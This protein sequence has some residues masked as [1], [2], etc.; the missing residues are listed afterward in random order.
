MALPDPECWNLSAETRHRRASGRIWTSGRRWLRYP[1]AR[2][3]APNRLQNDRWKRPHQRY[4]PC[5]CN[6]HYISRHEGL[7]GNGTTTNVILRKVGIPDRHPAPMVS[8]AAKRWSTQFSTTQADL[9]FAFFL[10]RSRSMESPSVRLASRRP[11][12]QPF[13]TQSPPLTRRPPDLGRA[14]WRRLGRHCT[15]S[16]LPHV[17]R[18]SHQARPLGH[19]DSLR[20]S[21]GETPLIPAP[22]VRS[23]STHR[24]TAKPHFR[25][26]ALLS[27]KTRD[28]HGRARRRGERQS[29]ASGRA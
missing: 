27:R 25:V 14:K 18:R 16:D 3:E 26:H 2:V 22:S 11:R 29:L 20:Q 7:W 15:P 19:P 9:P 6:H 28:A 10:C 17:R 1:S 5:L 4:Q 23:G 8:I 12:T 13:R 24:Q 21:P